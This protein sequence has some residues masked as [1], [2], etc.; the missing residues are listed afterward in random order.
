M[1]DCHLKILEENGDVWLVADPAMTTDYVSLKELEVLN[2]QSFNSNVMHRHTLPSKDELEGKVYVFG[3]IKESKIVDFKEGKTQP[4]KKQVWKAKMNKDT[5]SHR[6]MLEWITAS[7]EKG[8]VVGT[9]PQFEMYGKEGNYSNGN[10]LEWSITPKPHCKECNKGRLKVMEEKDMNAKLSEMQTTLTSIST[11]RDSWKKKFEDVSAT[12]Q[13]EKESIIK[14]FEEKSL[15]VVKAL[16]EKNKEIESKLIAMEKTAIVARKAPYIKELTE[17][18]R[19]SPLTLKRFE[20]LDEKDLIAEVEF[21]R[22]NKI[23]PAPV[24]IKSMEESRL[25]AMDSNE[26]EKLRASFVEIANKMVEDAKKGMFK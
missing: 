25:S 9:S 24:L 6:K 21:V 13:K 14:Q 22:K 7:T 20:D 1:S 11:D 2:E 26:S 5:D 16:E 23:E 4:A 3:K 19:Y 15:S 18:K 10:L 8:E 12:V 17:S